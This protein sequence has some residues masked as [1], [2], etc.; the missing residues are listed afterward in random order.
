VTE[1]IGGFTVATARR[2]AEIAREQGGTGATDYGEA[3]RLPLR[4]LGR[5]DTDAEIPRYACVQLGGRVSGFGLSGFPA[6]VDRPARF[7]TYLI[8]KPQTPDLL[9]L[10]ADPSSLSQGSNTHMAAIGVATEPIPPGKDR[11]IVLDGWMPAYVKYDSGSPSN[12]PFGH[13]EPVPGEHWWRWTW[14]AGYRAITWDAD[15]GSDMWVLVRL[16]EILNRQR[17]V[18]FRTLAALGTSIA[19]VQAE[20]V[21]RYGEGRYRGN[22]AEI[23]QSFPIVVHNFLQ[24]DGNYRWTNPQDSYGY[25]YYD[26]NESYIILLMDEDTVTPTTTT[27]TTTT[28][29]STT[30]TTTTSS[31]TTTTTTS[32]TTSTTTTPEPEATYSWSEMVGWTLVEA[33]P[34]PLESTPPPGDGEFEGQEVVRPCE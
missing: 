4:I 29:S 32:T 10:G 11:V 15:V 26:D 16:G 13:V 25:A 34:V 18:K 8:R 12:V 23:G 31:T 9:N 6:V 27:T 7:P 1:R 24:S 2:L 17:L 28:T 5:N 3:W 20:I 19:T 21:D 33:C 14:R 22:S 30:T